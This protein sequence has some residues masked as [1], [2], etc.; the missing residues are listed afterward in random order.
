M[1]KPLLAATVK[2]L[3]TITYPVYASVKLDGVR[4]IAKDGEI[5]SRSN[6]PIANKRV[7]ELLS[8]VST[9]GLDG[10]LIVGNACS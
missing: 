4:A 10:E 3:D 5:R 8:A 7:Q 1:F 2:D 6:K 9:L